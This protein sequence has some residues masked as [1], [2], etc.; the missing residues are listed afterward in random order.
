MGSCREETGEE[1]STSDNGMRVQKGTVKESIINRNEMAPWPRAAKMIK[2]YV[3]QPRG[4]ENSW[5]S[6]EKFT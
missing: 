5:E 6:L 1:G 3:P 4:K 2:P